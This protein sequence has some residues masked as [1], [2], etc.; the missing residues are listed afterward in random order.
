MIKSATLPYLRSSIPYRALA[1]HWI[2]AHARNQLAL[3]LRLILYFN[4][5]EYV[6]M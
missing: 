4:R 6:R 1:D 3:P 5:L 2:S